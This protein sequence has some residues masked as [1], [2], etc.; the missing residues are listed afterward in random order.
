MMIKY[1]LSA[2]A[3]LV[4][5]KFN[6]PRPGDTG[7]D[8]AS[9]EPVTLFRGERKLIPTGLRVEV[10]EGCV[11]LMRERSSLAAKGIYLHAGVIDRGFRGE[12]Q[13]LLH[14]ASE[15]NYQIEPGQRIAQLLFLKCESKIPVIHVNKEEF[16]ESIRGEL[17]FGSTG[18]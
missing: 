9:A 17:G 4:G 11:G 14:N 12:I 18:K 5:A 8:I 16:S 1:N 15:T 7:Y 13:V 10:P 2:V 6:T 3:S